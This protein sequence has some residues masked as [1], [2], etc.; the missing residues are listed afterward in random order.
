MCKRARKAKKNMAHIYCRVDGD[1]VLGHSTSNEQIFRN[2]HGVREAE[3][4]Q[5]KRKI[6]K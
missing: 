1:F 3:D 4:R 6:V 2:P 5:K